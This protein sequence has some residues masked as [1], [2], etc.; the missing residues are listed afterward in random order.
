MGKKE[1]HNMKIPFAHKKQRG[2]SLME[3]ALFL[4]IILWL[5]AGAVDFGM[6]YFSFVQM[7]D[8]AQEGIIYGSICQVFSDPDRT[9]PECLKTI[10]ERVRH[11]SDSTVNPTADIWPVNLHDQNPLS[12]TYVAVAVSAPNTNPGST[13]SVTLR[14]NYHFVV[15]LLG[16]IIGNSYIPLRASATGVI[17]KQVP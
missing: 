13:I 11:S 15:P 2:Q 14:Y 9:P 16:T 5:L 4:M 6:A 1:R 10:E 3:M 8:A 17:L 12:P 7:R